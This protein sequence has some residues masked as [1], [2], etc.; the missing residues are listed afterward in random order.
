MHRLYCTENI[1]RK[2]HLRHWH[3]FLK[4]LT[5]YYNLLLIVHQWRNQSVT[6]RRFASI[7]KY[8]PGKMFFF[9]LENL[10]YFFPPCCSARQKKLLDKC[11]VFRIRGLTCATFKTS[12]KTTFTTVMFYIFLERVQWK[13]PNS[14]KNTVGVLLPSVL[15]KPT[16]RCQSSNQKKSPN[17]SLS[18]NTFQICLLTC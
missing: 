10:I 17:Q 13:M 3:L 15:F 8:I 16:L 12:D 5:R 18:Q 7:Y 4:L 14:V 2:L 1:Q 11:S 6:I 9:L